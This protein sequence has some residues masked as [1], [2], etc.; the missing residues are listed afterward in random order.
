LINLF[1]RKRLF[2]IYSVLSFLMEIELDLD[3]SLEENAAAYF[4]KAKGARKKVEGLKRAINIVKQKQLQ[5]QAEQLKK[6]NQK[7]LAPNGNLSSAQK[8]KWFEAFRWF[9]TSDNLLVV[10]GKDAHSNEE[11]V[12][13]RMKK[14]DAYFHAEVFGAPHCF[15]QAPEE[16][17]KK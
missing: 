4:E 7:L 8:R 10:G 16:F 9:F 5:K 2:L 3:K 13:K 15:I 6:Q 11:I 1:I 17:S 14:N 12:K